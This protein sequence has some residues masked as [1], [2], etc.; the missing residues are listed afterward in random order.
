MVDSY[1]FRDVSSQSIVWVNS[2]VG[3]YNIKPLE[4][5]DPSAEIGEGILVAKDATSKKG[6]VAANTDPVVFV[7]FY[8]TER[9]TARD[10][11]SDPITDDT[12]IAQYA[13]GLS[14]IEGAAIEIGI[15]LALWDAAKAPAIGDYVGVGATLGLPL[16][17]L[18]SAVSGLI[19]FGR[20]TDI[21]GANRVIFEFSSLG[22]QK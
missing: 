5:R 14:G 22:E 2:K 18:P 9:M 20:I 21:D 10:F 3:A 16:A 11:Q 6:R 15:P 17:I 8:S 13:G 1:K 7:N 4:Y 12:S 19:V